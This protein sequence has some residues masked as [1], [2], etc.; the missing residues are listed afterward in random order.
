MTIKLTLKQMKELKKSCLYIVNEKE[1]RTFK[2]KQF[3]NIYYYA[4]YLG[5]RIRVQECFVLG[6]TKTIIKILYVFWDYEGV[7]QK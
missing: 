1:E 7:F 4:N 3:G 6:D 5:C 2:I